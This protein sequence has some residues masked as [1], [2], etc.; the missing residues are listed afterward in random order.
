MIV[1]G[2]DARFE[3]DRAELEESEVRRESRHVGLGIAREVRER[4]DRQ[5]L[6]DGE[7]RGHEGSSFAV[8]Y[9]VNFV[10]HSFLDRVVICES[11]TTCLTA[12][13]SGV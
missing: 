1:Q 13:L 3:I 2:H 9:S 6:I 10:D 7:I 8:E 12:S 11:L 5:T 4:P